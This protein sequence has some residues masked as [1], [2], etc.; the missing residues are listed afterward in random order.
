MMGGGLSID[1]R[2]EHWHLV[3]LARRPAPPTNET[4]PTLHTEYSAPTTLSTS[5]N[6]RI[7]RLIQA[8]KFTSLETTS[9]YIRPRP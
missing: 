7:T 1:Y 4:T 2:T 9:T 5:V 3:W 8:G 6:Y